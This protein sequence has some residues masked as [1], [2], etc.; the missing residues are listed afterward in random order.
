MVE[1]GNDLKKVF[2]T[3]S[4]R[5]K[6]ISPIK[7]QKTL[8][9]SYEETPE[10][11]FYDFMKNAEELLD[12]CQIEHH[13][14]E[15]IEEFYLAPSYIFT[16]LPALGPIFSFIAQKLQRGF[17][18]KGAYLELNLAECEIFDF[19]LKG[20]LKVTATNPYGFN[21]SSRTFSENNGR[22]QL[23][24]CRFVNRGVDLENSNS[25]CQD[26]F[27]FHEKC[28]I[29]LEGFSEFHAKDIEFKGDFLFKVPDG[30]R[31]DV[32]LDH[33]NKMVN[34]LTRLVQPSWTSSYAIYKDHFVVLKNDP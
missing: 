11:C 33:D 16:Y 29:I 6:T 25:F 32:Y 13:R 34:E 10:S 12:L 14:L 3:L 15:T 2:M 17:I 26:L 21:S 24:N 22:V 23:T 1:E 4:L 28:E 20:A 5:R 18:E 9:S 31:L 27:K 30:Y 7:K 8:S 19:Y